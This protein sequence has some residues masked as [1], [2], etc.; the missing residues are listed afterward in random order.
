MVNRWWKNWHN[1]PGSPLYIGLHSSASCPQPPASPPFFRINE[2]QIFR[3]CA[4]IFCEVAHAWLSLMSRVPRV[5][6]NFYPIFFFLSAQNPK[7]HVILTS[8][9]FFLV[10]WQTQIN[11]LISVGDTPITITKMNIVRLTN[12]LIALQYISTRTP[13]FICYPHIFNISTPCKA[14]LPHQ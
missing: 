9:T 10:T 7:Y 4:G 12:H 1:S 2:K 11:I 6:V 3:T 13:I 8:L 5:F 14:L